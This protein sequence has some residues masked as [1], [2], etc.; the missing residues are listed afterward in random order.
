VGTALVVSANG[1]LPRRTG[2]RNLRRAGV[3]EGVI[4]KIG[5][6][7]TSSVFRRYDIIDNVDT[8]EAVRKLDHSRIASDQFERSLG[9]SASSE[10]E[11][12]SEVVS[13]ATN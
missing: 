10:P 12:G 1:G 3:T 7:K 11:S 13:A 5:G 4:M 6:W 9:H 2:A 8:T